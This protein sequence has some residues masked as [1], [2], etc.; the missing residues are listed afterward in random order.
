[1]PRRSVPAFERGLNCGKLNSIP[2][3]QFSCLKNRDSNSCQSI[4]VRVKRKINSDVLFF[5]KIE[6]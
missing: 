4:I 6:Y 1:M 2:K 5:L 3:T